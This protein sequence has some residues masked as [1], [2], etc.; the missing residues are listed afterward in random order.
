MSVTALA[1]TQRTWGHNQEAEL[2]GYA[3]EARLGQVRPWG[4]LLVCCVFRAWPS[5]RLGMCSAGHMQSMA[6]PRPSADKGG[7][8]PG[9]N[10]VPLNCHQHSFFVHSCRSW[11]VP[12]GTQR[13]GV[14]PC[15]QELTAPSGGGGQAQ[16]CPSITQAGQHIQSQGGRRNDRPVSIMNVPERFEEEHLTWVLGGRAMFLQEKYSGGGNSQV[17]A[18]EHENSVTDDLSRGTTKGHSGLSGL[19]L[20]LEGLTKSPP[21]S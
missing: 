13:R 2:E 15:P 1:G 8:S 10:E 14:C 6:T 17:R 21:L 20:S 9:A 18:W 11:W 16:A 5:P 3:L 12:G 19:D 4:S 7:V